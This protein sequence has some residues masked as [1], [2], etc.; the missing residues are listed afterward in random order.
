V[1]APSEQAVRGWRRA[2]LVAI[3]TVH[4]MAFFSIGSCLAYFA[5][6]SLARR[7][8]RRAA[9]AGAVVTGEALVYAVNGFRCPLTDLAERLGSVHGSVADIYLPKWIEAHL[10]EITGP[11]F[12]GALILHARNVIE[13]RREYS[14]EVTP[15][16]DG[17]ATLRTVSDLYRGETNDEH[18]GS[19]RRNRHGRL[20]SGSVSIGR[21]ATWTSSSSAWDSPSSSSMAPRTRPP[22]RH[23]MTRPSRERSR[24]RT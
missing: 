12:A 10:P 11:I 16:V 23:T 18:G 14:A 1:E 17:P 3:K 6:S 22:T 21:L 2:S 24:W 20:V 13:L 4:T 8:D 15:L 19:P 5:Y 7:S 9:I